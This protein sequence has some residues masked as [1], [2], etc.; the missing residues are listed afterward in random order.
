M[1]PSMNEQESVV[2]SRRIIMNTLATAGFIAL[3]AASMWLAVYSTRYVPS[4]ANRLGAAA[5]YLGSIF[6]PALEPSLSV[7]PIA[8][9]TLSTSVASTTPVASAPTKSVVPTAGPKTSSVIQ[10]G[11]ATTT[12]P[13]SGLPD[14]VVHINAVGYLASSSPDSFVASSTSPSGNRPAVNFT[15]KNIGT[16][17]SGTWRFSAT[18][19]TWP[20][21]LFFSQPQQS[22]SPGDSIDYTLGFDQASRGIDQTISVTANFDRMVTESNFTN[23]NAIAKLTIL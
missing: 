19:P 23:D 1:Y 9:S 16:N 8:T 14:L 22:L 11:G 10:I 17:V 2:Q 20:S 15:I 21:Y 3:V 6:T 18:I 12:T 5:V 7:I 13:L 4:V